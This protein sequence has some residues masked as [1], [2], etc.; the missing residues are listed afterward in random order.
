MRTSQDRNDV[1]NELARSEPFRA[2]VTFDAEGNVVSLSP[3][4][5][6]LRESKDHRSRK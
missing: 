5:R 6:S 1:A 3:E 2:A 4:A